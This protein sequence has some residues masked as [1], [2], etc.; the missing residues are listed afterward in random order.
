MQIS[1]DFHFSLT[2]LQ[3]GILHRANLVAGGS[4]GDE[5]Y[6]KV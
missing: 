5:K 4:S 6:Q 1:F 3:G 2:T